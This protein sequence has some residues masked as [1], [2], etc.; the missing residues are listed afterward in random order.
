MT[1]VSCF[2]IGNVAAYR[3]RGEVSLD[4]PWAS[5]M[6]AMK[7]LGTSRSSSFAA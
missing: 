4:L 7:F 3:T 5:A 1:F 6:H 2:A